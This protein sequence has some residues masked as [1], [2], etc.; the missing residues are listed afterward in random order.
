MQIYIDYNILGRL[1]DKIRNKIANS[2]D[3]RWK[4]DNDSLLSIWNAFNEGKIDLITCEDDCYM[5][6]LDYCPEKMKNYKDAEKLLPSHMRRKFNLFKKLRKGELLICPYGEYGFD[7]G[8]YGGGQKE[9][10]ELLDQLRIMLNRKNK[11]PHKDRDARHLMHC[12]LYQCDYFLTMDY[13]TIVDKFHG[14]YKLIKLYLI[15]KG[16]ELNVVTPGE[17][18]RILR[19]TKCL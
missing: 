9:N 11:T 14:R 1:D 5:E 3:S 18:L 17:L 12:I 16:Y 7:R 10:Y 19:K 4:P 8:P 2:Q 15:K 13:K 6:F